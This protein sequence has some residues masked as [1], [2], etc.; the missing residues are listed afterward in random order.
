MLIRLSINRFVVPLKEY[1]V[2]ILT[3]A[4][5]TVTP[6]FYINNYLVICWCHIVKFG[7]VL[8]ELLKLIYKGF[9]LI[10]TSKWL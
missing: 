5:Q 6:F 4:F 1:P 7:P 9:S 8:L 2:I 10:H 3:Y